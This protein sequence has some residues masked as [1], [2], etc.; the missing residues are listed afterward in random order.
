MMRKLIF[1]IIGFFLTISNFQVNPLRSQEI[2][3]IRSMPRY[4]ATIP[5]N[6][7]KSPSILGFIDK[8]DFYSDSS[9]GSDII[10]ANTISDAS[11][12]SINSIKIILNP[13]IYFFSNDTLSS[14]DN[15]V[16]FSF[17]D[18]DSQLS[19]EFYSM[20][21]EE[22]EK[23]LNKTIGIDEEHEFHHS[24][25]SLYNL[26]NDYKANLSQISCFSTLAKSGN[27]N[28]Q[29]VL[30]NYLESID[31]VQVQLHDIGNYGNT[32]EF[33]HTIDNP[34]VNLIPKDT[35]KTNG[36]H[37]K[38]GSERGYV[39]NTYN[40][41]GNNKITSIIVYDID[42]QRLDSTT[43]DNVFIRPIITRNFKY[44]YDMNLV[45]DDGPNNYCL[46]NP[47]Y[48]VNIS[49][50]TVENDL[51]SA[52]HPNVGDSN[53]NINNDNGVCLRAFSQKLVGTGKNSDGRVD[54]V[55]FLLKMFNLF[56]QMATSKIPVISSMIDKVFTTISDTYENEI[57]MTILDQYNLST[58]PN[59]RKQYLYLYDIGPA[60][61]TS[62][63]NADKFFKSFSLKFPEYNSSP[64]KVTKEDFV[65]NNRQTPLLFKTKEDYLSYQ[66]SIIQSDNFDDYTC[67]IEHSLDLDVF[68]DNSLWLFRWDPEFICTAKNN[69]SYLYSGNIKLKENV[70]KEG[71]YCEYICGKN[72]S[73]EFS[74]GPVK[75][76]GNFNLILNDAAPHTVLSYES[77]TH[78][79]EKTQYVDA[80]GNIRESSYSKPLIKTIYLEAGK[81]FKFNIS[82][83]Y[84]NNRYFGWGKVLISELDSS[85][86]ISGTNKN[87]MN[88]IK[89][90]IEIGNSSLLNK[91]TVGK[92]DFYTISLSSNSN[93]KDTYVQLYDDNYHLVF[94]D[95][96]GFGKS[97]AGIR[98]PLLVNKNYYVISRFYNRSNGNA[99]LFISNES[100]I[101]EITGVVSRESINVSSFGADKYK[102]YLINQNASKNIYIQAVWYNNPGNNSPKIEAVIYDCYGNIINQ[103]ND[104]NSG[105]LEVTI[106]KDCLYYLELSTT[107]AAINGMG[108][109]LFFK[110][111]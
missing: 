17:F 70:V 87:R 78:N 57:L 49:Y 50:T 11:E 56:S 29:G 60:N 36:I 59:N 103:V 63:K 14:F 35:F 22:K 97:R 5:S 98:I 55:K 90:K 85:E 38:C 67:L 82:N 108:L 110:N 54:L 111:R 3:N 1:T 21:S 83:I 105:N 44:N 74:F 31:N 53:Y 107:N 12:N 58:L 84:S 27:V 8:Y 23:V 24:F 45:Y 6:V 32:S 86:F 72:E 106:E 91:L 94:E 18:K 39:A 19:K 48:R 76:S 40:D 37:N 16:E 41:D 109:S 2:E 30:N 101:P 104:L 79:V 95:D 15:I 42:N 93:Y 69:W 73:A 10:I 99:E 28:N 80:F 9:F 68:N 4:S 47:N 25:I 71:E 51:N 100:Y 52:V 13:S 43:V 33:V 26:E 89:K 46:G 20:T 62:A 88:L 65:E 34:I 81:T 102:C 61:I 66:F 92:S 75:K 77:S 7:S 96:D 64:D